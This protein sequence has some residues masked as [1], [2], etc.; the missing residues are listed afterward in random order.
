VGVA[1]WRRH[2]LGHVQVEGSKFI[3]LVSCPHSATR[4]ITRTCTR[5]RPTRPQSSDFCH[6]LGRT[7]VASPA[8]LP[9]CWKT[10]ARS[11]KH[12][13]EHLV[14]QASSNMSVLTCT[15]A[16]AGKL[17]RSRCLPRMIQAQTEVQCNIPPMKAEYLF[18][19]AELSR[20]HDRVLS[21]HDGSIQAFPSPRGSP[22]LVQS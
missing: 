21:F 12:H 22:A 19:P 2:R 14:V 13:P 6:V 5:L 1:R 20:Y 8:P 11:C 4:S 18:H 7:D 3:K 17:I 16:R 15:A 9:S 10:V